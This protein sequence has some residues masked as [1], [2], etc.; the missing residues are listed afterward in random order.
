MQTNNTCIMAKRRGKQVVLEALAH[1][2]LSP[3]YP[4]ILRD[5]RLQ[6][7]K[8]PGHTQKDCK[9]LALSRVWNG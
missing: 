2:R 7:I 5:T 1:L 6:R 9:R 3:L 8:L 4:Y